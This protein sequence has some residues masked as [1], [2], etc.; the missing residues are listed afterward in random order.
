MNI[1]DLTGQSFGRLTV[2]RQSY[3][4]D[5]RAHWTCLCRCGNQK[6]IAGKS[7]RNGSTTSCGCFN[8]EQSSRKNFRHGMH[9]EKIYFVWTQ[10]IQRCKNPSHPKAKYYSLRGITVCDRWRDF[11]N[12]LSDMGFPPKGCLLDRINNDGNYE[13]SNC[14]WTDAKTSGANRRSKG[15]GYIKTNEG[16]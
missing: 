4:T 8:R 16:R 11:R 12:F 10:M 15:I 6:R 7:L 14:R 3:S 2:I 9:N 5:G 1:K 13:P